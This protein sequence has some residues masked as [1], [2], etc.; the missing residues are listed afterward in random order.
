[1][2]TTQILLFTLL[3][4]ALVLSACGGA[5]VVE[6]AKVPPTKVEAPEVLEPSGES[7]P[8]VFEEIVDS[9]F[10]SETI[11]IP[12]GTTVFWTH[13]G[14]F[15]HTVTLD[16]GSYDSGELRKG[17]KVSFT[18]TEAGTYNYYCSIHGSAG[19]QGMSGVIIVIE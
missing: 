11:T 7:V 9:A 3:S 12:V 16:N 15:P 19:G 10:D 5:T 2:K 1:M 18:F 13:N 17:N 6:P 8:D 14:S 4:S